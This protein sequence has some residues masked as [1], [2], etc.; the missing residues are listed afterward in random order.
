LPITLPISALDIFKLFAA[1]LKAVDRIVAGLLTMF[2]A[3]LI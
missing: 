2:S 3:K 1:L